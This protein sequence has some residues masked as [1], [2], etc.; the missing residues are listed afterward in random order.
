MTFQLWTHEDEERRAHNPTPTPEDLERREL[1]DMRRD[2]DK[3]PEVAVKPGRQAHLRLLEYTRRDGRWI[4]IVRSED[5]EDVA[6]KIQRLVLVGDALR[7]F[8]RCKPRPSDL[9]LVATPAKGLCRV[10]VA[11]RPEPVTPPWDALEPDGTDRDDIF[12]VVS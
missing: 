3:I 8:R 10:S 12:E 4:A 2:L 7:A 9:L 1:E 11:G 6:A 5:Q